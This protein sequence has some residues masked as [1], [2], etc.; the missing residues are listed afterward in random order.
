MDNPSQTTIELMRALA[1]KAE[2]DQSFVAYALREYMEME[3]ID[4]EELR[5]RLGCSEHGLLRLSLCRRPGVDSPGFRRD[6]ERCAE[7]SGA[8]GTAL[9]NLLK[10]VRYRELMAE[11]G[12]AAARVSEAAEPADRGAQ[13]APSAGAEDEQ[14]PGRSSREEPESPGKPEPEANV[15]F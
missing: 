9:A 13:R 1:K 12:I 2:R 4:E 8:S 6:V 5:K 15:L 11:P 7:V 14:C 3:R 10:A